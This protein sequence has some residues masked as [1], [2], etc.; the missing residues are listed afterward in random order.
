M[1]LDVTTVRT[2]IWHIYNKLGI[3]SRSQLT[4]IAMLTG[5]VDAAMVV[6]ALQQYAPEAMNCD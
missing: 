1:T 6:S 2:Y 5:L 3:Q 4:A